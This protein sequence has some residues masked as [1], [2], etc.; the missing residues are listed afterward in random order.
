MTQVDGDKFRNALG[1][2]ATGV[3]VVTTL[4]QNGEPLGITANSFNSVSL[5]PPMVL[6]SIAK[7]SGKRS[8]FEGSD[9][10]VVNVLAEDQVEVSQHFAKS[11]KDMFS[12]IEWQAGLNGLPL[13]PACAARFQCSKV[14][15]YDGGDHIIIV[16]KVDQFDDTGREA[17]VFHRGRYA[18]V[19]VHPDADS[20]APGGFEDDFLM[21]L[22]MRATYEFVEPFKESISSLDLNEAEVRVLTFLS[23]HDDCKLNKLTYGTMLSKSD[24]ESAVESLVEKKL[25]RRDPDEP[26]IIR[27]TA[28]G[29]D[30]VV[31]VMAIAKAHETNVL[32]DYT[33]EQ[34]FKLKRELRRLADRS[35]S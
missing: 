7:E 8:T 9:H 12:S 14:Y 22:L 10:F 4:D 34:V 20:N 30:K 11:A 3:T 13:L 15:Q 18:V 29:R 6:W 28:D 25:V 19:D 24:V 32:A 33:P 23:G 27:I 5:D 31:P 21:A 35:R 2:F 17:L 16:G 26:D 1:H